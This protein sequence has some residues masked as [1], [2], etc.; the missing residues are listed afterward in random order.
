M[1]WLF[2]NMSNTVKKVLEAPRVR[3]IYKDGMWSV[4]FGG[5]VLIHRQKQVFEVVFKAHACLRT[6]FCTGS[7]IGIAPMTNDKVL[8][9]RALSVASTVLHVQSLHITNRLAVEY[10]FGIFHARELWMCNAKVRIDQFLCNF[11]LRALLS[12]ARSPKRRHPRFA[13]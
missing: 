11:N 9:S 10:F 7:P 4:C 13:L 1:I 6:P 8:A 12:D 5:V 3:G 2:D